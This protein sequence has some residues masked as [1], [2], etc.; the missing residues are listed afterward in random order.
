MRRVKKYLLMCLVHMSKVN[1]GGPSPTSIV[2]GPELICELGLYGIKS[3][4]H[5]VQLLYA[6]PLSE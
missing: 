5:L 4:L 6:L 2:I 3:I 1:L